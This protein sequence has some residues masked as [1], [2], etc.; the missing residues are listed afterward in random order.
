MDAE[1]L[2]RKSNGTGFDVARFRGDRGIREVTG[3]ALFVHRGRPVVLSYV[4]AC[5]ARGRTVRAI[6]EEKSGSR[7][8]TFTLR[9][10]RSRR[11]TINGRRVRAVDG[12]ED[13]D[14]SFT[15]ATNALAISRLGL[16]RGEAANVR[17]AWLRFPDF[18]LHPL[19]QEYRRTG[20]STYAYRSGRFVA[21]LRVTRSGI[22]SRY[23]A[24]WSAIALG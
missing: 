1:I 13:A 19:D 15:P 4:V 20:A 3:V 2:W 14:L 8:R 21:T 12:C 18:T 5:D 17:A 22:V 6:V 10:D 23:G 9:A 7:R 16:K 11:W 24:R